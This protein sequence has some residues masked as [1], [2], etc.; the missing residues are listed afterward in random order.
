M[1]PLDVVGV[2]A[3]ALGGQLPV[4]VQGPFVDAA[5]D[6]GAALGAVEKGVEIPGHLSEVIEE[7]RSFGVESGEVEAAVVVDLSHGHEAPLGGVQFVVVGLL[8]AGDSDELAVVAVG[9]AMVG[10]DEGGGVAGIGAADAVAAVT[11]DVEEGVDFAGGVTGHKDRVFAHVGGEEVA[12]VR[13]L[14]LMAEEEPAAGEDALLF[15]LVDVGL[16]VNAAANQTLG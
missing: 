4:G 14:G 12:W 1:G 2:A 7:R 11:A 8:E 10:A 5:D 9:P 13:D 6:F 16:D 3:E 15:L